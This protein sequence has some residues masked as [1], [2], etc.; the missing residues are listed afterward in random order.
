[1]EE[2]SPGWGGGALCPACRVLALGRGAEH[3]LQG[4][5]GPL[6]RLWRVCETGWAQLS[7]HA[8][9]ERR[10]DCSVSGLEIDP[11]SSEV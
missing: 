5:G 10:A 8:R 9:S 4:G 2:D 7:L 3:L 11:W 1:M 6:L